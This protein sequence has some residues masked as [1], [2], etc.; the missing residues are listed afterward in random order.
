[1]SKYMQML[2]IYAYH[3]LFFLGKKMLKKVMGNLHIN[4]YVY[5]LQ[6][7]HLSAIGFE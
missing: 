5:R 3:C 1:M 2:I 4:E 7:R 6:H